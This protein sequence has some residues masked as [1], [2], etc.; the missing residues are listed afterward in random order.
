MV[1]DDRKTRKAY[2]AAKITRQ[3]GIDDANTTATTKQ[4][5]VRNKKNGGGGPALTDMSHF[6]VKMKPEHKNLVR[7]E[8]RR[9]FR[10]L[11]MNPN[12][13]TA[14]HKADAKNRDKA[15]RKRTD[16]K[17]RDQEQKK[18]AIKYLRDIG[19]LDRATKTRPLL[20][21]SSSSITSM[22][23]SSSSSSSLLPSL[24][25]QEEKKRIKTE[26]STHKTRARRISSKQA[27]SDQ[28]LSPTLLSSSIQGTKFIS[29]SHH[30]PLF[31]F[32]MQIFD[33]C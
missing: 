18:S 11:V 32:P 4:A 15:H 28:S 23:F 25:V 13:T 27:I 26:T 20:S 9:A 22:S 29:S 10:D 33:V 12:A 6:I 1:H 17:L 7:G 3:A 5:T 16:S 21:S 19:M 24:G 30:H 2:R 14:G 8:C 31:I